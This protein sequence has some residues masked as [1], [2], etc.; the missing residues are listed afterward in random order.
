MH[1]LLLGAL[2]APVVLAASTPPIAVASTAD[3]SLKLSLVTSPVK[4]AGTPGS[5]K[6]VKVSIDDTASGHK[7]T[8]RGFG[9]AV[10]DST[11]EVFNKLSSDQLSK[12]LSQLLSSG[13]AN[14]ALIRHTIGSSDLSADPVYT[15]DDSNGPD[16]S[17]SQFSLGSRGAAMAD[18]LAKMK[19]VQP[20]LTLLGTPW[21][22]PG[23]MKLNGKV[24]GS[25]VNNNLNPQYQAEFGAYFAKYLQAFQARGITVDAITI[26][27]EPLNSQSGMPTLYVAANQS[28]TLIQDAVGPAIRNAG[29]HT[30]V[31]AYDHN[32][33]ESSS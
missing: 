25:T 4:G 5:N 16:T 21:S 28:G 18:L 20:Q 30:S 19:Q 11:V 26:Q 3:G 2:A 29:L 24:I 8:V 13:G 17:L 1:L 31:W 32:T 23:W 27:N 9:A 14:F 15:Y 22:P 7:Q 10:T 6:T 33:G 12:L